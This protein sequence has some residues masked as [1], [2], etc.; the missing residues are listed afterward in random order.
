MPRTN[1]D[2]MRT[3][4]RLR[5]RAARNADARLLTRAATLAGRADAL[6]EE[7]L[8][9]GASKEHVEARHAQYAEAL[10]ALAVLF[11]QVGIM[12]E[13][14]V[15]SDGPLDIYGSGQALKALWS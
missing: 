6:R 2:A 4:D 5:R 7:W 1:D 12:R 3:L 11:V 13:P 9:P 10:R 15:I 8:R 14:M